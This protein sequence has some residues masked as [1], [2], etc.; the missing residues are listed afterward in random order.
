MSINFRSDNEAP[1][2]PEILDAIAAVNQG[3]AHS[4]G[5]DQLTADLEQKFSEIFATDVKV[6]PLATGTAANS[7][8]MAQICEPFGSIYCHVHAHMNTDECGAPEF[9]T[10]GAKLVGLNGDHGKLDATGLGAALDE[11]GYLDVHEVMP[12]ALSLS[13]ATEFGT[14]YTPDEVNEYQNLPM[15]IVQ[16][17]LREGTVL[18]ER[19][20]H[21]CHAV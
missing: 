13:Q 1:V 5:E 19:Q 14:V 16:T 17:A 6:W 20:G 4:Y 10:A 18:Y 2:A 7:L 21:G 8:A 3:F 15:S 12:S 11:T 9:F